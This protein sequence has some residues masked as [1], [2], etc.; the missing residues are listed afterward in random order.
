[1]YYLIMEYLQ[2]CILLYVFVMICVDFYVSNLSYVPGIDERFIVTDQ[3]KVITVVSKQY[4]DGRQASHDHQCT[5]FFSKLLQVSKNLFSSQSLL[6][7]FF[8]NCFSKLGTC[9]LA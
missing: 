5:L 6:G 3:T 8:S 9:I 4:I 2:V 1:M 7:I